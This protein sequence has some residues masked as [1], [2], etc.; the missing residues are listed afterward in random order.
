MIAQ[1]RNQFVG[2]PCPENTYG[3]ADKVYGWAA[4]PCKPCPRNMITD[5]ATMVSNSSVCINDNGFGYASEGEWALLACLPCACR[6][7]GGVGTS[8]H[9]C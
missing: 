6:T 4:A 5:G 9:A 3:A 2:K 1:G 8:L 7:A